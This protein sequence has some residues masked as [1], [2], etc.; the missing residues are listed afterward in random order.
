MTTCVAQSARKRAFFGGVG[1]APLRRDSSPTRRFGAERPAHC[2]EHPVSTA[3][4][5]ALLQA[6][7]REP[8]ANLTPRTVALG[9]LLAFA[10]GALTVGVAS[11]LGGGA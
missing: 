1:V 4:S 11:L 9:I 10:L 5:V 2:A 6:V 3:W 7:A 8:E